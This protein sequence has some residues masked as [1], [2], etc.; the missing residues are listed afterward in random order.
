MN[1]ARHKQRENSTEREKHNQQSKKEKRESFTVRELTNYELC[2]QINSG[3]AALP[4]EK[5]GNK[6]FTV[7][8]IVKEQLY[9]QRNRERRV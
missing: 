9:R 2:R 6:S 8:A 4:S 5:Q 3:R 1:K 7:R